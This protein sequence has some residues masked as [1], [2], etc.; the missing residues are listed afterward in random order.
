MPAET[1]AA[2]AF[3]SFPG[4]LE[5][6][7]WSDHSGLQLATLTT[8]P[9]LAAPLE[10]PEALLIGAREVD[11]SGDGLRHDFAIRPGAQWGDGSPVRAADYAEALLRAAASSTATG[12]WLRHVEEV[13]VQDDLLRVRLSAPDFSF[14]HLTTLPAVAPH[15]GGDGAGSYRITASTTRT[16]SLA[17]QAHADGDVPDRLVLRRIK[18]P[19]LGLKA[20]AE[21]RVDMT[22]DTAFPFHRLAD[23]A[24]D[25][26]FG[27]RQLGIIVVLGFEGRL[28]RPDGRAERV[29]IQQAMATDALAQLLPAPLL[30]RPDFMP[31]NDFRRSYEKAAQ[32]KQV[33][34]R[35]AVRPGQGSAYR[36]A[37][38]TYYPNREIAAV[39]AH[40]LHDAGIPAVLVPDRYENRTVGT[41][42]RINLFRG[43]HPDRLGVY[44]GMTFL[45]EL[46][47]HRTLDEYVNT[48]RRFDAAPTTPRSVE[49]ACRELTSILARDALC[50]PLAEVPGVFLSRMTRP[51]GEWA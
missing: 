14:P 4:T 11:S 36:I 6:P 39:V 46:R 41:D 22:S 13:T 25:P 26:A 37:Y 31:D 5:Q 49:E 42:L 30:P 34:V 48:L 17:R 44:R 16:I 12:Y 24:G 38:D 47:S 43:L 21:G 32:R 23:F 10:S 8:R 2:L 19:V 33:P 28:A 45:E 51:L 15:R 7:L 50:V 18:D 3:D 29:A 40:L 9:L 1:H 27:V 35:R 20:Y